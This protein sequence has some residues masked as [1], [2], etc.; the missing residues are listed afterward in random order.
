MR[1]GELL[2]RRCL[3]DFKAFK[4][5]GQFA[6]PNL[7]YLFSACRPTK[8]TLFKPLLPKAET[9]FIPIQDFDHA[10]SAVA[11]SEKVPGENVEPHNAAHH[12]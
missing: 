7:Q 4:Q 11:E 8:T 5:P 2:M 1:N 6:L 9:V 10:A 3:I 12:G